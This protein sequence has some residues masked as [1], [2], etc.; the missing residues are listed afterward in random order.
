MRAVFGKAHAKAIQTV[1]YSH[2]YPS[3]KYSRMG[4][5]RVLSSTFKKG[6]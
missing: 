4:V 3:M 2:G 6:D 1:I 5:G